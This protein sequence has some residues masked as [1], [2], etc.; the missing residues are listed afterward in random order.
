VKGKLAYLVVAVGAV[1]A[2]GSV[3]RTFTV[4]GSMERVLLWGVAA[5]VGILLVA[6]GIGRVATG[7]A[8]E[9]AADPEEALDKTDSRFGRR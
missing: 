8:D 3:V 5:V 4:L 2:F 6:F 9:G 7:A 1:L